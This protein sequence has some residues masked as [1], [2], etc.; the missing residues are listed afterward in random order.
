M[1]AAPRLRGE[2][3][4]LRATARI[5]DTHKYTLAEWERRFGAMKPTLMRYGVCQTFIP[6]TFEGDEVYTVVG[7]RVHPADSTGWT[8]ILRERAGSV[9]NLDI[10]SAL[11][12]P[13]AHRHDRWRRKDHPR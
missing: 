1:V 8:A 2:G 5:L 10:V 12:S 7:Q 13:C 3:M 11:E 6:L 9:L 4:G